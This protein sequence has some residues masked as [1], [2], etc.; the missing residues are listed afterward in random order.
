MAIEKTE[1]ALIRRIADFSRTV[2]RAADARAP[3]RLAEYAHALATD[4]HGFYTE[5]VVLG[6]DDA[7]TSSR[8]SLCIATKA[9]LASALGL[10]GV[11]A[12]DAM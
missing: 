10:L 9:V 2:A 1:I 12:P 11:S 3:Q 8:L 7:L 5:C 4:F 6:D